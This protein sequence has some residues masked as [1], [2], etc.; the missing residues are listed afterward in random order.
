MLH[1]TRATNRLPAF[2]AYEQHRAEKHGARAALAL[3]PDAPS[4]VKYDISSAM[5]PFLNY[6][7]CLRPSI[8]LSR[9]APHADAVPKLRQADFTFAFSGRW[10]RLSIFG[11]RDTSMICQRSA[12]HSAAF[13]VSAFQA[14]AAGDDALIGA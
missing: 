1:S 14:F 6:L 4:Q 11:R 8:A 2:S 5:P 13:C 9:P 10:R 3:S 7:P 12:G